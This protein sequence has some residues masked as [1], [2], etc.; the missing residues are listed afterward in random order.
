MNGE[1]AAPAW[2]RSNDIPAS[3]RAATADDVAVDEIVDVL[4]AREFDVPR[5]RIQAM[6]EA[7]EPVPE[8]TTDARHPAQVGAHD[9]RYVDE[10]DL[11]YLSE[12]E[13]AII[14]GVTLSQFG[15]SYQVVSETNDSVFDLIWMGP[16]ETVGLRTDVSP[17]EQ[18]GEAVVREV[19]ESNSI[20]SEIGDPTASCVVSP[21]EFTTD[22]M[23]LATSN[24]VRMIGIDHLSEWLRHARVSPAVLGSFREFED[25]VDEE[26]D[27]LSNARSHLDRVDP[28]DLS[29]RDRFSTIAVDIGR[30][31]NSSRASPDRRSAFNVDGKRDTGILYADPSEDGDSEALDRFMQGLET[32]T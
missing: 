2:Y 13:L 31:I 18:A 15:G 32:D 21:G 9:V 28:F 1:S 10:T 7:R 12:R 8:S 29:P 22:A 19:I 6:I 14:L 20:A 30:A 25:L 17:E 5:R 24:N 4:H 3:V 16:D 11:G 23:E 26:L 27:G